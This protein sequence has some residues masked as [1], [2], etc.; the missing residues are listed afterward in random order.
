[1]RRVKFQSFKLLQ[2]IT[3][4]KGN[5]SNGDIIK[6]QLIDGKVHLYP[7]SHKSPTEWRAVMLDENLVEI[8]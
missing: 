6:G 2:D 4:T 8:Q 1:M 3:H 7:E 5:L